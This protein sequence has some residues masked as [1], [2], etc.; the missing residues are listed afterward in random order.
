[1]HPIAVRDERAERDELERLARLQRCRFE[2]DVW[3]VG[4][5]ARVSDRLAGPDSAPVVGGKPKHDESISE[6]LNGFVDRASTSQDGAGV[7]SKEPNSVAAAAKTSY[8]S[9]ITWL[10]AVTCSWG[11]VAHPAG[12]QQ[13]RM[14]GAVEAPRSADEAPRTIAGIPPLD[15]S[16]RAMNRRD[17]S[18]RR[19]PVVVERPPARHPRRLIAQPQLKRPRP[20]TVTLGTSQQTAHPDVH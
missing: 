20:P 10:T 1:L 8:T 16:P 19:P 17:R 9:G 11:G 3:I 18:Q 12:H 4:A 5:S 13:H 14:A 15:Q 6:E 7:A 2:V